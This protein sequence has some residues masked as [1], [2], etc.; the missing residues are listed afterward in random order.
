MKVNVTNILDGGNVIR[1]FMW[2]PFGLQIQSLE[3]VLW[4]A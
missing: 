1:M 3:N 2:G 4:R